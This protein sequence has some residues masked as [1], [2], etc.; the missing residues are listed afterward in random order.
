MAELLAMSEIPVE[1]VAI[2]GGPAY[3]V[4]RRT[5]LLVLNE[6]AVLRF[7]S[8]GARRVDMVDLCDTAVS[9]L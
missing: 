7:S 5:S 4:P 1:P 6:G 9:V 8:A 2:R 3:T